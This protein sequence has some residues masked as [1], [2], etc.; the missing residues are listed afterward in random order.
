[1]ALEKPR[2]RYEQ[3]ADHLRKAIKSG[4]YAPGEMLPSQP[5]LAREFGLAQT[6]ITRA[7]GLLKQEGL[8]QVEG[9]RG[10]TVLEV[11]TVKRTRHANHRGS[12]GSFA[13]EMERAGLEPETP[14]VLCDVV[15]PPA[16]IANHLQLDTEQVLLR[17]RHMLGSKRP[18]QIAASYIPISIAGG[19]DIAYPDTG[20]TGMYK[21]L[22][23][24]GH[25][26][27]RFI[28]EIEVRRSNRAEA[29]FFNVAATP[30]SVIEVTRVAYD[31]QDR[32]IEATS[33][34]F[35][36]TQWKLTYEWPADV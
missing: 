29:D 20:P 5:A 21:R 15:D 3:V 14:L 34:V 9:G 17:K 8:V 4:K 22:A 25:R 18:M 1:M 2:S 24:R 36:A 33:N 7:I 35:P 11:P 19:K 26:V 12:G 32:P 23:E 10:A 31:S 28:E 27:T 6:S 13:S 30:G 16:E